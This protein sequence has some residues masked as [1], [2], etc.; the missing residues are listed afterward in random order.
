M[1]SL[2]SF[3]QF[4]LE[5]ADDYQRL[6]K[7]GLVS[8]NQAFFNDVEKILE[9]CPNLDYVTYPYSS[10]PSGAV[11]KI[12]SGDPKLNRYR[13]IYLRLEEDGEITQDVKDHITKLS[14]VYDFGKRSDYIEK[15]ALEKYGQ[16]YLN[17]VDDQ[18]KQLAKNEFSEMLQTLHTID[19]SE[20]VELKIWDLSGWKIRYNHFKKNGEYLDSKEAV[21]ELEQNPDIAEK[22]NKLQ[23]A[24]VSK[25]GA[26]FGERMSRGDFGPLD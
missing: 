16:S 3:S 4:I 25:A 15:I 20:E 26:E 24:A 22:V 7:L 11:R 17:S 23:I 18:V 2:K 9:L 1:N 8:K 5:G 6:V 21:E 19:S 12:P 10:S 13:L 14:R